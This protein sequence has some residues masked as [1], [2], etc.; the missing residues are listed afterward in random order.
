MVTLRSVTLVSCLP[1]ARPESTA[2]FC[3]RATM[4][5]KVMLLTTQP[6]SAAVRS[7]LLM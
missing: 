6:G 7:M 3:E 2:A 4:S 5:S 1:G